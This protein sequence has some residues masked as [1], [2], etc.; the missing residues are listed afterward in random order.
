MKTLPQAWVRVVVTLTLVAV[1]LVVGRFLWDYYLNAPWTRDGRVCADVVRVTPDISGP[2]QEVLVRDNQTVHKGDV[3]FRVDTARFTL[4]LQQS[5]AALSGAEASLKLAQREAARRQKLVQDNVVSAS[6]NEQVVTVAAQRE[7][8]Y[9]L[10]LA[11]RDLA[12]LNLERSEIKAPVNGTLSNFSLRPGGY[13]IAGQPV[14]ALVDADS[15]YIAGYFE[16]TKLK[17]IHQGDAVLVR[18]MGSRVDLPGRVA[19]I[20]PGIEDRERT[21]SS[22]LLANVNPTFNWV[23]LAQ[24]IPVRIILDCPAELIAGQTATVRVTSPELPPAAAQAATVTVGSRTHH[25]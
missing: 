19:S 20:A 9:Q 7:A 15:Y 18:L 17:H 21:D 6:E 11:N 12:R 16:E 10:A 14:T 23:R 4:A 24:R 25:S 1:A 5:E 13:V 3:L 8:D 2:V 22:R